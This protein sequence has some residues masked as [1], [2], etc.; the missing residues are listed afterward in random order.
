MPTHPPVPPFGTPVPEVAITLPLV[1]GLLEDQHPDLAHLPLQWVD[2]G[3]DNTMVRLGDRLAVRLPH[4]ALAVPLAIHEHTWLPHLA[5]R[6]PLPIPTPQRL[7]H[8]ALGYPWP[9]SIVPWLPGHPADQQPPHPHQVAPWVA[10]LRSLHQPSPTDAPI[11]PFRAMPLHERAISLAPRMQRL[12]AQTDLLNPALLD[13]WHRAVNTP[14]DGPATWIHGDLHARNILV[15]NGCLSAVIDW[16][17]ITAG[18]PAT[19]LASV[20]ML[21]ADAAVRQRAIADYAP[22]QATLHRALGWA[23]VFGV[24]LLDTGLVDDPRHAAVGEWTLR[25]VWADRATVY[26]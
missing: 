23:I 1:R 13:L 19:D 11:N 14:I 2:A 15:E 5:P 4:R 9:W 8:S 6:L 24:L 25:R 7:G 26:P 16:G 20:W 21:F 3:F 18:D 10:F 12:A 22:S 17:D